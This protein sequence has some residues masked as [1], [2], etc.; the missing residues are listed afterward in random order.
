M[1]LEMTRAVGDMESAMRRLVKA[2]EGVPYRPSGFANVRKQL[3][4][5]V[6][7]FAGELENS[8]SLFVENVEG[9]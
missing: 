5:R 2:G 6:A 7:T 9:E 8:A 1:S 3:A 4:R